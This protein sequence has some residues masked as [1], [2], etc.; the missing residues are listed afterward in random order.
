MVVKLVSARP[1]AS[2]AGDESGSATPHDREG[3]GRA[4][5]RVAQLV[6]DEA[7]VL[8]GLTLELAVALLL[9]LVTALPVPLLRHEASSLRVVLADGDPMLLGELE[10]GDV[11][12]TVL[13]H[14]LADVEAETQALHAV[15]LGVGADLLG[16]RHDAGMERGGELARGRAACDRRARPWSAAS[17]GVGFGRRGPALEQLLT[18]RRQELVESHAY[19]VGTER[20]ASSLRGRSR[21]QRFMSRTTRKRASPLIMRSYALG[22]S[23]NGKIS[24]IERTLVCRAEG[25]RV[26]RVDR[27]AGVDAL[28]RAA[29]AD[30]R[31]AGTSIGSR[32]TPMTRSLP[33]SP[34]PGMQRAHRLAA[35]DRRRD[36]LGAAELAQLRDGV[37]GLTVEVARGAELAAPGSP[38]P[39]RAPA[40][41]SVKPILAAYCTARW[42]RPPMP[43]TA[44]TSPGPCA[45]AA[46][47][48]VGGDAGA[49]QRRRVG[50]AELVGDARQRRRRRDHVFGVAAVEGGAGDLLRDAAEEVA[51]PHAS[52]VPS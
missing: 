39:C 40:R 42:P 20:R 38:C 52:Q 11:Q 2:V 29:S 37:L 24:F 50:G 12:K 30:Q 46:K 49:H 14:D 44:T 17:S 7:E 8:G 18:I 21:S 5:Q 16:Q 22:A 6:R 45:A 33:L 10:H 13:A 28:D 51:A 23:E 15:L 43:R 35:G 32:A 27:G 26:F 1:S 41:S 47:R 9:I 25:E 3:H 31:N 34:S 36:D 19:K 48:V 4:R